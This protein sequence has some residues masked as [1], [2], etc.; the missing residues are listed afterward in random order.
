M[1]EPVEKNKSRYPLLRWIPA[2]VFVLILMYNE[3]MQMPNDVMLVYYVKRGGTSVSRLSI[4]LPLDVKGE[5]EK[6]SKDIGMTQ[7]A[8]VN[9]AVATMVTKYKAEGMRIFFDLI[10]QP[11]IRKSK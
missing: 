8:L 10:S 4:D 5:L 6:M 11:E 2:F 9:L 3:V 7:N 1:R